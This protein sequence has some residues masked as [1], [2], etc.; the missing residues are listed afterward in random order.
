MINLSLNELKLFAKSRSIQDYKGE[1]EEDLIKIHSKPKPKI[2]LFKKKI[3]EIKKDFNELKYSFSRSKINKFRRSLHNIKNQNL[4]AP[5]IKVTEKIF[6]NYKKVFIILGSI[7]TMII[8]NT[9]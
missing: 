9:K 5:E 8:L 3:K 2:N 6:L 7:M 4:S 1:S